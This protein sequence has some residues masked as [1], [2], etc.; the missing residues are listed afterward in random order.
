VRRFPVWL[1]VP[2]ALST[3]L[4]GGAE[5]SERAEPGPLASTGYILGGAP[6]ALVARDAHGLATLGVAAV[7]IT[8]DGRSVAAP[9]A[10]TT[11]MVTIAHDHGLRAELLL[12]NYSEKLQDFDPVAVGRL[13]TH[14]ARIRHVAELLAG[15]V[16]ADGWDGVQVDLERMQREHG[17]G[18]VLLVRELQ[19]RMP[20]DR[21]VS[22]AISASGSPA[23]YRERGYR[24]GPLG[25]AADT[26]ALMTYDQHG[27]TWSGPGPV[28]ARDWQRRSLRAALKKVDPHKVDL[29]IAGYGYTWPA[30]GTGRSV[31]VEEARR[32]VEKDGA[33]AVWKPGPG[34]W[35]ARLSDG[36][37]LWWSDARSY[38][39][40]ERM[41]RRAG[42]HG[43]ALWRLGS[44]DPIPE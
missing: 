29:G 21:S 34:E 5:G 27:P 31:E 41:A 30:H 32:L 6:A 8:A 10:R 3:S 9:D 15:H 35:T 16:A 4:A 38:A 24:L 39:V 13:L 14:P 43:L 22:I 42:L 17:T 36:T 28:G 18:L 12:S 33:R 2:V 11:G 20:A 26:I 19:A 37:V 23:A 44:A 25:R 7:A 1:V 40:R